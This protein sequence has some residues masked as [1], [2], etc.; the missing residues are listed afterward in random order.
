[1]LTD[2]LSWRWILFANLP[3]AALACFVTWRSVP[4]SRGAGAEEGIDVPGVATLSVGLVA[5]LLALDQ[6]TRLGLDR[7]AHPRPVRRL[8]RCCSWRSW[9][10]SAAPGRARWCRGEVMANPAFRAACL[11]T[12]LMSAIFFAV[13][14]YLPQ[15]MQKILG[16]DP[17][18]AGRGAAAADGRVRG[19]LVRGRAALRALRG[20]G[21]GQRGCRLPRPSAS[22]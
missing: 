22:S 1:M 19:H 21:R 12:L 13:L 2:A 18:E 16:W 5:L 7:P 20:E 11:A 8:C 3:I 17:L 9:S 10:S 15:F 4:E 14:L 6:V